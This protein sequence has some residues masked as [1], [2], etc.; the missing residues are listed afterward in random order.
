M[1]NTYFKKFFVYFCFFISELF[2][3]LV[4]LLTGNLESFVLYNFCIN[5][6][7]YSF[8]SWILIFISSVP[9]TNCIVYS[10]AVSLY[11]FTASYAAE[12]DCVPVLRLGSRALTHFHLCSF[13]SYPFSHS[14]INITKLWCWRDDGSVIKSTA[15]GTTRFSSQYQHGA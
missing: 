3:S 12:S 13:S 7:I 8:S 6:S 11:C 14:C 15:C 4:H 1:I 10:H 5:S 9:L 2:N